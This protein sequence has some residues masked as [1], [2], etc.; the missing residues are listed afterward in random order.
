[1]GFWLKSNKDFIKVFENWMDQTLVRYNDVYF[2]T[3]YQALLWMTNPVGT[4]NLNG[5]EEWKDKCKVEGQPVC[6][7]PNECPLTSPELPRGETIRLWTQRALDKSRDTIFCS[8]ESRTH[9]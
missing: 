1:M 9:S 2:V 7:L 3:N 5:F 6:S 4:S 8:R